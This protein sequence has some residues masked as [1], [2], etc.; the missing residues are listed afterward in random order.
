MHNI[1]LTHAT[2]EVHHFISEAFS[3]QDLHT[4]TLTFSEN[5]SAMVAEQSKIK[6][7]WLVNNPMAQAHEKQTFLE[8]RLTFRQVWVNELRHSETI[9]AEKGYLYRRTRLSTTAPPRMT[10]RSSKPHLKAVLWFYEPCTSTV[11]PTPLGINCGS[12]NRVRLT[13]HL[14]VSPIEKAHQSEMV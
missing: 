10:T 8:A 6:L 7:Q 14:V 11:S 9:L 2:V 12:R 3:L 4:R 1:I 13:R 5:Q